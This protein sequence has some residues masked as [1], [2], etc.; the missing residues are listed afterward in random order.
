VTKNKEKQAFPYEIYCDMDGV[1]VDLFEN[2]VYLEAK[3]PKLCKN[4][5]KIIKMRWKWSKDHK[6]PEI[7]EALVWIRQ[8]LGNNRSFW[9]NLRPLPGILPFW[10]YLNSLGTVKILS[11]PWDTASAEGKRDWIKKYLIPSPKD[12]DI[13]LPLDGK[14]EIWATNNNKPCILIDDF[15]TYTEKWE[16]NGGIAVLHT[17]NTNTIKCLE[18]ILT[19]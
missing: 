13:F 18:D 5:E 15:P 9:A 17:S 7:Q 14:K 3:D 6:N 12:E 11:H 8:L 19:I 1:L 4:L 16:E 2:G 10:T